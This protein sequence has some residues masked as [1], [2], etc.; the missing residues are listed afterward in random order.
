MGDPL[1]DLAKIIDRACA[2]PKDFHNEYQIYELLTETFTK[3]ADDF[4]FK[5]FFKRLFCKFGTVTVIEANYKYAGELILGQLQGLKVNDG[6]RVILDIGK[7]NP[8][9]WEVQ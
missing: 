1:S 6:D 4:M 7:A 2:L 5:D 8:E 3:V 9:L